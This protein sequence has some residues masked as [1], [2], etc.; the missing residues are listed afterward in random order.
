MGNTALLTDPTYD[1]GDDE[2]R[3]LAGIISPA[4][5][6][7]LVGPPPD[8]APPTQPG[9]S[10]Q[11]TGNLAAP[12]QHSIAKNLD[13]AE[14]RAQY[15][16]ASNVGTVKTGVFNPQY[17]AVGQ[18]AQPVR[19]AQPTQFALPQPSQ[20]S[21]PLQPA[22]SGLQPAYQPGV[23]LATQQATRMQAYQSGPGPAQYAAS[24][25]PAS[26]DMQNPD[27]TASL[28]PG[29]SN[30]TAGT[31]PLMPA[32]AQQQVNPPSQLDSDQA[33]LNQLKSQGSGISQIGNRFGK[34]AA[35]A[36]DI[37]L[38]LLAPG[39]EPF[40]PGTE[41]HH[42][43]LVG[44]QEGLVGN[45]QAQAQQA[46]QTADVNSQ[47]AERNAKAAGTYPVT[48]TPEMAAKNPDLVVG[49]QVR[50]QDLAGITK[51]STTGR[52][53]NQGIQQRDIDEAP[54]KGMKAV[55]DEDNPGQKKLVEDPDNPVYQLKQAQGRLDQANA[56]FAAAKNDPTSFAGKVAMAKIQAENSAT[57]VAKIR[58][59]AYM[60]N[61]K[62][63][64][65]GVDLNNNPLNAIGMV[66]GAPVGTSIMP[67]AAKAMGNVAKFQD[68]YSS[69][70][71]ANSAIDMG[72]KAG[73]KFNTAAMT[74]A[75]SDP[76]TTSG[77][78]LA[79]KVNT[80]L[81][82]LEQNIVITTKALREQLNAMRSS[83]GGG[84]SD[85]QVNRLVD[86][87]PSATTPDMAYARKQLAT[88]RGQ[89]DRLQSGLPGVN[90]GP[91]LQ[92][93]GAPANPTVP[94]GVPKAIPKAQPTVEIPPAAAKQL[95]EG[96]VHT[97]NNGQK[98]TLQAGKPVRVP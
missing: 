62:M 78:W 19:P 33:R 37:A 48:V 65:Q 17:G 6:A 20:S 3:A 18:A 50:P 58:A 39:I 67:Q 46:A 80:T 83:I 95:Q 55:D 57:S 69:I 35:T 12:P 86:Q 63:H 74:E 43:M 14:G 8:A 71:N 77:Q 70:D 92:P 73:A 98:W 10:T 90:N 36:G 47:A 84:V 79:G 34:A 45:D 21:R 49:Q 94:G 52:L 1:P 87:L 96:K 4:P 22:Q 97:F 72:D 85:T 91:T 30:P 44:Q 24:Q 41:G 56:D 42:Q 75:L 29:G 31:T 9:V 54:S 40:I 89:L 11:R 61:Y 27:P 68:I 60:G 59:L 38:R 16:G 64:A 2:K 5:A 28:R 26:T 88:V 13:T 82:P 76:K 15:S 7:Q 66:G 51:A 23:P 32:T 53:R 25:S 81:N 93:A